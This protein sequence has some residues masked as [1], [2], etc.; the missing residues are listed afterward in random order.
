MATTRDREPIDLDKILQIEDE[1]YNINAVY[2][3]EAGKTSKALKVTKTKHDGNEV[4]EFDGHVEEELEVV[5]AEG[6]KFSG[7]I[8]VDNP[9]DQQNNGNMAVNLSNVK[10]LISDLTG[11]PCATWNGTILKYDTVSNTDQA[12]KRVTLVRGKRVDFQSFINSTPP[13]TYYLYVC[14]D[15]GEAFFYTK[16]NEFVQLNTTKLVNGDNTSEAYTYDLLTQLFESIKA[17][18]TNITNGSTL[19]DAKKLV[20]ATNKTNYY[21]YD[22]LSKGSEKIK[23]AENANSLGSTNTAGTTSLV[24]VGSA[25]KPVYFSGGKPVSC[26][27]SLEVSITGNA[28]TAT[29]ADYATRLGSRDLSLDYS[30]VKANAELLA[31]IVNG[32][33]LLPHYFSRPSSNPSSGTTTNRIF[34]S[35]SEPNGSIGDIWIKYST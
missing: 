24:G 12:I 9:S 11:F 32:D 16:D 22:G 15:T 8:E 25:S 1:E 18:I 19:V 7:Y 21:T 20:S 5:P 34:I 13:R 35:T 17:S 4:F 26:D 23:Q 28:A 2:S 29:Q 3:D 30:T 31:G 33:T 6:G 14:T 10:S 27:N